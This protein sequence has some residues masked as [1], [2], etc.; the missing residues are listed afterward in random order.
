[1]GDWQKKMQDMATPIGHSELKVVEPLR[2]LL[3]NQYPN[4]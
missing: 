2:K 4:N 3:S 1:M